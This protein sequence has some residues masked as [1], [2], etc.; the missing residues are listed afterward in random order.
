MDKVRAEIKVE[1][2]ERRIEKAKQLEKVYGNLKAWLNGRDTPKPKL[3]KEIR[4]KKKKSEIIANTKRKYGIE[5]PDGV[6]IIE[7]MEQLEDA[8]KLFEKGHNIEFRISKDSPEL[9]EAWKERIT[10]LRK[11]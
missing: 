9:I 8:W 4:M 2:S 11:K 5:S 10:K 6:V 7:N 1:K 3:V